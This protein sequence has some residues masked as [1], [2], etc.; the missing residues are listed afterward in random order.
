MGGESMRATAISENLSLRRVQQFVREQLDRRN[1]NPADDFALLQ[2]ARLERAISSAP[3]SDHRILQNGCYRPKVDRGLQA[4]PRPLQTAKSG[5]FWLR[6]GSAARGPRRWDHVRISSLRRRLLDAWVHL[7]RMDDS[8]RLV[9]LFAQ[10]LGWRSRVGA[11]RSLIWRRAGRL[12][13]CRA[14]DEGDAG[15]SQAK[16]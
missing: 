4:R 9:Q 12:G 14:G 6:R 5:L 15:D 13:E 10:A 3:R 1:S 8:V 2:I 16:S 7:F 11:R